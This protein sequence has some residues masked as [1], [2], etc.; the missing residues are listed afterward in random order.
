[1]ESQAIECPPLHGD[2]DDAASVRRHEIDMV[3]RDKRGGHDQVAFILA[4]SVIYDDDQATLADLV[5]DLGD[6][7]DA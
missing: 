4:V 5:E 3:R 6:R 1:M 2:A 7:V